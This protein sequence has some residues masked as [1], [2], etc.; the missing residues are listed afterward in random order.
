MGV[1]LAFAI[2]WTMARDSI[3]AKELETRRKKVA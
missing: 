1:A 3:R 2:V